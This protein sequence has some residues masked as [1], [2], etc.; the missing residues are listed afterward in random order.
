MLF[1][2]MTGNESNGRRE[3]GSEEKKRVTQ[4]KKSNHQID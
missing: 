1:L 3:E 4:I 2:K